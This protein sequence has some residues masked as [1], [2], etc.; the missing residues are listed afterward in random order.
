[1]HLAEAKNSA[2]IAN[3]AAGARIG[4]T[5]PTTTCSLHMHGHQS[6]RI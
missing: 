3:V 1:M 6:A 5:K 2:G 4:M